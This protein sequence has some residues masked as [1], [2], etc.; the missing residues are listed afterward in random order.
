MSKLMEEPDISRLSKRRR[1][2]TPFS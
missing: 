1:I 2:K